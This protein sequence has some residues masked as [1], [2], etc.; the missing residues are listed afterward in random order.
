MLI[1]F[2]V[3]LFFVNHIMD[4]RK[5]TIPVTEETLGISIAGLKIEQSKSKYDKPTIMVCYQQKGSLPEFTKDGKRYENV[6]IRGSLDSAKL[7][8]WNGN[9]YEQLPVILE[10]GYRH[11]PISENSEMTIIYRALDGYEFVPESGSRYRFTQQIS[12]FYMD[13]YRI[14]TPSE[15]V[16]SDSVWINYD[17]I[18]E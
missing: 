9:T 3:E 15:I 5:S 2:I 12:V 11:Y 14:S 16:F 6:C 1:F 8:I 13:E 17:F 18:W 4:F 7:F 10:S